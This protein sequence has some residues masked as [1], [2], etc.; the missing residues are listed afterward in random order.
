MP[1]HKVLPF[2]KGCDD[3]KKRLRARVKSP[4]IS[5]IP[6]VQAWLREERKRGGGLLAASEVQIDAVS[7]HDPVAARLLRA[8]TRSMRKYQ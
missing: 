6:Q 3:I 1:T 5:A 8:F 4:E 2:S 7:A